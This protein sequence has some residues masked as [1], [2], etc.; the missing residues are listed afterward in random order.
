[1]PKKHHHSR[2][3]NTPSSH[4]ADM[5][6]PDLSNRISALL[7]GTYD[8]KRQRDALLDEFSNIISL[9]HDKVEKF[10]HTYEVIVKTTLTDIANKSISQD[11][12]KLLIK[13][14]HLRK[15]FDDFMKAV[16]DIN[17]VRR[18]LNDIQKGLNV[19]NLAADINVDLIALCKTESLPATRLAINCFEELFLFAES[20]DYLHMKPKTTDYSALSTMSSYTTFF[21]HPASASSQLTKSKSGTL[22]LSSSSDDGSEILV[23]DVAASESHGVKSRQ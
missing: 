2:S 15:I 3:I 12:L 7:R 17:K 6:D 8:L 13:D 22:T 20:S 4:A 16:S 11:D 1:M 19:E 21:S 18:R 14:R 23:Y 5:A 10:L 9:C